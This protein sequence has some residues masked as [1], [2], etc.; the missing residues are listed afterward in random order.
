VRPL[1]R[2]KR[3]LHRTVKVF[4]LIE[5]GNFTQPRPLRLQPRF[6]F[7]FIRN[8]YEIRRHETPPVI[9]KSKWK[10]EFESE[11]EM[12]LLL[13]S[14]TGRKP[15]ATFSTGKARTFS[16]TKTRPTAS[17]VRKHA[18]RKTPETRARR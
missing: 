6:Y 13:G 2:R 17:A 15:P 14:D 16:G 11:I 1:F 10:L 3:A 8:L 18:I 12:N 9:A 5:P 7:R 4:W